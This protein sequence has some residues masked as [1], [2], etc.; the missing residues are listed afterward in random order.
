MLLSLATDLHLD[1]DLD[2]DE[3]ILTLEEALMN[4]LI[5]AQVVCFRLLS[6]RKMSL[7]LIRLFKNKKKTGASWQAQ[8]G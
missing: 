5:V 8:S 4:N 6:C 3:A 1:L 7:C 2:F